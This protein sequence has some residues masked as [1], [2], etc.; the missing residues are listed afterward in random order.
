MLSDMSESRDP[1]QYGNEKGVS[2]NH[3][4][5]KM[6]N[7]ILLSVDKTQP[8]TNLLFSAQWLTG[9]RR[10]TASVLYWVLNL[11][12]ETVSESLLYRY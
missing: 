3:L 4:L 1:A 6:I 7:E 8:M 12:S 9:S 10:S 5:I 11:S 2:V